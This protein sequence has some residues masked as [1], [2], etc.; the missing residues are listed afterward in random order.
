MLA[1]EQRF[2]WLKLKSEFM[3][4]DIIDFLMSQKNGANYVVLYQMLVVKTINTEGRLISQ[5]GEML[6]PFNVD[7]I[8]RECKW[9]DTD[10]I[11]V[12][13]ELYK[14]L[15]LIYEEK[16]GVIAI[17]N[18]K[19]LVGSESYWNKQKKLSAEREKMKELE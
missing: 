1:K 16:N 3:Q 2:Y 9:F 17:S 14:Q 7:K 19:E 15:G 18:F 6:I 12:A 4:G 10:T 5:V 13:L 11:V 8:Q